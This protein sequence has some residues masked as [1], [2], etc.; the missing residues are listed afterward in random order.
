MHEITALQRDRAAAYTDDSDEEIQLVRW[1][2]NDLAYFGPLY[3]RYA[4]R[5]YHYCLRRVGRTEEAEDL[6]STIFTHALNGLKKYRG[7]SFAAWLFRI[8]H[9][10]VMSHFRSRRTEQ[11]IPVA[12]SPQITPGERAIENLIRA[13]ERRWVLAL[14]AALPDDQ[15]ELL[16]LK[17]DGGLSA[18]EIG[19][20]LGKREGA[21]R[22][23][24]YRIMEQLRFNYRQLEQDSEGKDHA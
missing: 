20:V 8:A 15:Q 22:I 19:V 6:T 4:P 21:I 2:R 1:A 16:A 18:K 11:P 13:E 5:I 3:E 9:N 10:T 7:G 24:I 12:S 14:I 17:V 23:A